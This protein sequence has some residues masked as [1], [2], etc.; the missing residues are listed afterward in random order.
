MEKNKKQKKIHLK[1]SE[2]KRKK[3]LLKKPKT[4]ILSVNPKTFVTR[5]E[6]GR[7]LVKKGRTGYFKEEYIKEKQKWLS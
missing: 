1:I 5:G 3:K 4:K 2:P 6:N 7:V